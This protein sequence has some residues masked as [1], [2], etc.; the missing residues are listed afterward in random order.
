MTTPFVVDGQRQPPEPPQR[1]TLLD[2]AGVDLR[3]T[4]QP[5]V[6]EQSSFDEFVEA[7]GWVATQPMGLDSKT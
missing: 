4:P 5:I 6:F 1:L 7:G 2:S 3:L